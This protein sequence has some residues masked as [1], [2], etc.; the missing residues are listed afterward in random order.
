MRVET[1]AVKVPQANLD[2][3]RADYMFDCSVQVKVN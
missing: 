3:L 2:Y 1:M